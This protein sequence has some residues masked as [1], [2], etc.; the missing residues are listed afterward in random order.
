MT[1]KISYNIYLN[2]LRF[3][4]PLTLF[5]IYLIY[6]FFCRGYLF[7]KKERETLQMLYNLTLIKNK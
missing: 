6:L 7:R 5:S 2:H 4:I 3:I 1:S